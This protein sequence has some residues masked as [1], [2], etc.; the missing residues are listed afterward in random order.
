MRITE[1]LLLLLA[2]WTAVGAVGVT[3]SFV[4]KERR[5]A[6]KNLGWIVGIWA[7]YLAILLGTSLLQPQRIV[8][9]GT[10]QCYDDMC[11]TVMGADEM[12]GYLMHEGSL[13]RV[14]ISITNRGKKAKRESSL[15]S[16]LLDQQG[17]KWTEVPGLTGV[18]LNTRVPPG[19]TATSE[20]VFKLP[21]GA[22]PQGLALT[23]GRL[24]PGLL[25]IGDPDSILH[26][27]TL[28]RLNP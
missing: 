21:H 10:P 18:S 2:G 15:R 17:R 11:F 9:T 3:A 5:K 1:I 19:G 23:H 26:R 13:V 7:V 4:Q 27:P 8:K 22:I 24:Q 20:P 14:R 16:Y 25:V 28:A 6:F 12:P